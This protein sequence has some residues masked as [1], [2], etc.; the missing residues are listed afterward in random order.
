MS[1]WVCSFALFANATQHNTTHPYP[2]CQS[3]QW[4]DRII[5]R[6]MDHEQGPGSLP[7]LLGGW[8]LGVS[9]TDGRIVCL[10]L[11][12]AYLASPRLVYIVCR[13]SLKHLWISDPRLCHRGEVNQSGRWFPYEVG[14]SGRRAYWRLFKFD[15]CRGVWQNSQPSRLI[16]QVFVWVL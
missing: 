7:G 3:L 6:R 1:P 14:R 9:Q 2:V 4:M 5:H 10:A 16:T 8:S 13:L 15:R 12:F 11:T